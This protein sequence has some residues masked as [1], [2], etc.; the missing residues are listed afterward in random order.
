MTDQII[1]SN[2]LDIET[3]MRYD[4]PQ[5]RVGTAPIFSAF[6]SMLFQ[7]VSTNQSPWFFNTPNILDIVNCYLTIF[8]FTHIPKSQS[9]FICISLGEAWSL[10]HGG[11]GS[12]PRRYGAHRNVSL[13]M[14]GSAKILLSHLGLVQTKWRVLSIK[15]VWLSRNSTHCILRRRWLCTVAERLP[16]HGHTALFPMVC[17]WRIL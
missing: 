6:H 17:A 1:A 14:N 10:P 7:C 15:V 12:P 13:P 11:Y 16:Q 5:K 9:C 2:E 8:T 3:T 4:V